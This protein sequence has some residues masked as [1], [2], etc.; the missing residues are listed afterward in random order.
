MITRLVTI[1]E[2]K[3]IFLELLLNHTDKVS[4]VSQDSVLNGIAFGVAKIGQRALKDIALAESHQFPDS[5]FG[6]HLDKVAD[7]YGV[8]AR[9]GS[10]ESSTYVRLVA[11]PGTIY[12]T[13]VHT[14]TGSHGTI[15]DLEADI[16]IGINGFEYTKIRSQDVGEKTNVDPLS[17]NV[18]SPEPVG[19]EFV[20]NEYQATGGRDAEQDDVFR[21][22]IK[23]GSNILARNTLAYLT[24]VFIKFNNN[25]LDVYY[26]GINDKGQ[27]VIA[28]L[29]QNGINLNQAEL[30]LLTDSGEKFFSLTDL[31]PRGTK[32]I[33]IELKNVEYQ[34]FDIDFRA[35]LFQDANPDTVRKDIQ[36][37][38]SK[39]LDFRFWKVS[40]KVEW[41]NLLQIVKGVEGV[42]YVADKF[43]I[44]SSDIVVDKNKA[45]RLRGFLMRNLDGGII[46]DLAGN[47]SP[48]FYPNEPNINFQET[49]L[50]SI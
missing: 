1:G 47:L 49:A 41:D 42:R 10:S 16:T 39:E 20:I 38:I 13:G 26:Q 19:H 45:P 2:L 36:V 23:E 9:F 18:V 37:K 50:S 21:K 43:F 5:A 29:T 4:K 40:D 48:V 30:D 14:F 7:N 27:V 28:I 11:D 15:F 6:V 44:P 34:V 22:R 31:R 12:Q 25:I 8:A 3:A 35:E 32:A 33:N 24:Q 46:S 17:I